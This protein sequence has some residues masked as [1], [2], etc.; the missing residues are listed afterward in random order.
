MICTAV[1]AVLV[2]VQLNAA[3]VV[4]ATRVTLSAVGAWMDTVPAVDG[5]AEPVMVIAGICVAI[6]A[7][8]VVWPV[9]ATVLAD[10]PVDWAV[11][12]RGDPGQRRQ[13]GAVGRG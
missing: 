5:T 6:P 3:S 12:G 11:P 8:M 10:S 7:A 4:P 1:A 2:S 13:L 9:R